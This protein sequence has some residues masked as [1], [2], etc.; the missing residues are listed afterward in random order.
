MHIFILAGEPSGD[1]YGASLMHELLDMDSNIKFSGIGGPLM[2]LQGLKSMQPLSKMSVMGFMEI[3]KTLPFFMKLEKKIIHYILK[4]NPDKI[5]LIDY[6]GLNLRLCEKIKKQLNIEIV[7]YIS[8]QVWAWKENRVKIIKQYVDKLIVIFKFEKKWYQEKG[9]KAK[10][11]GH[12]FLD[13]WN[14]DDTQM[15]QKDNVDLT[16]PILTLFPGSRTQEFKRHIDLMISAALKVKEKI[17]DLQILLG[18]HQNI[19]YNKSIDSNIVVV[20]DAPLK[21]L[22][23]SNAAIIA[24]GTATLQ[25]A[26]MKVPSVVIYKMNALSWTLTKNVIKAPFASMANIIAEEEVFPELLQNQA[27]KQNLVQHTL[28]MLTQNTY[29]T[30]LLDKIEII[31]NKIG[32]PGASKRAAQYIM[33]N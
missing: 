32:G 4:N 27:T 31:K 17:P 3:F 8:P 7:Y 30:Q 33:D 20:K 1:E 15:M 18:L 16:K 2:E 24:S 22:A 29:R 28:N 19:K 12:P 11:V 14:Y 23:V 25:A 21:A 6:P 26:I 5:I 9:L 13:I 10:Y